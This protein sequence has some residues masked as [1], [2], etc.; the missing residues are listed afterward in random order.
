MPPLMNRPHLDSY[1]AGVPLALKTHPPP[2]LPPTASPTCP[3]HQPPPPPPLLMMIVITVIT[4]IITLHDGHHLFLYYSSVA[5][6]TIGNA[7]Y[8]PSNPIPPPP[9][10]Q[11]LPGHPGLLRL[12]GRAARGLLRQLAP[13]PRPHG[14]PPSPVPVRFG[15]SSRGARCFFG[16]SGSMRETRGWGA[17]SFCFLG[18]IFVCESLF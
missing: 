14:R 9:P 12:R 2:P 1:R 4:L 17:V 7:E 13:G 15:A 8:L 11:P 18:G 10:L 16:P 6:G 3:L 5:L